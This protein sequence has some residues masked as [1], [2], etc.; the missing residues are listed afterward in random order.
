VQST[1]IAAEILRRHADAHWP[2]G[3]EEI[4]PGGTIRL[5]SIGFACQIEE[6]CVVPA[7]LAFRWRLDD[8][9]CWMRL[10]TLDAA[11]FGETTHRWRPARSKSRFELINSHAC[12]APETSK[13]SS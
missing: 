13:G 11:I 7:L 2:R 12:H 4:G 1:R 8:P 6:P 3:P 10:V 5:D 9:E